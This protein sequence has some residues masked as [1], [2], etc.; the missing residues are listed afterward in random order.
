MIS[1]LLN[2]DSVWETSTFSDI[3]TLP[4]ANDT[5]R[6][7]CIVAGGLALILSRNKE[8]AIRLHYPYTVEMYELL[9]KELRKF[10]K[11][12]AGA[13]LINNVMHE[14]AQVAD[15]L[16]MSSLKICLENRRSHDVMRKVAR[17]EDGDSRPRS[18]ASGFLSRIGRKT[19]QGPDLSASSAGIET[20][21]QRGAQGTDV[22]PE[23]ARRL[24]EAVEN[25]RRQRS[26]AVGDRQGA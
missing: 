19:L 22:T 26:A 12:S 13:G 17:E 8:A 4:N 23:A 16:T 25:A 11:T 6:H 14:V 10:G 1:K 15:P 20:A 5:I 3:P 18:G 21:E 24:K 2:P 7:F 9:G